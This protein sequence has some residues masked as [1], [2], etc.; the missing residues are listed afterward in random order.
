LHLH[1]IISASLNV[2]WRPRIGHRVT[3]P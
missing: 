2:R 1:D 3:A